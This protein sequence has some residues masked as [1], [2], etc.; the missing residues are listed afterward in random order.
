MS[1]K[2]KEYNRL[3][4]RLHALGFRF[5]HCKSG[6]VKILPPLNFPHAKGY[7]CHPDDKAVGQIIDH[8]RRECNINMKKL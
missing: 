3:I 2:F 7:S 5:E 8:I 4:K 6:C 1:H